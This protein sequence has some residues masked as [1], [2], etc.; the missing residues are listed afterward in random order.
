[1]TNMLDH[2]Q[3]RILNKIRVLQEIISEQEF[4]D[5]N[6][7]L[8]KSQLEEACTITLKLNE[9][10]RSLLKKVNAEIFEE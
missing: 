8:L 5:I 1:M 10:L 4:R 6:C 9:A 3:E 2:T 7:P